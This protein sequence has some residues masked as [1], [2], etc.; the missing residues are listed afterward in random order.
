MQAVI[1]EQPGRAENVLVVRDLYKNMIWQG[2]GIDSWL[3]NAIPEQLATAQQELWKMLSE[4]LD[5][6]PVIDSFNPTQVHEALH[7]VLT[8]MRWHSTRSQWNPTMAYI[9]FPKRRHEHYVNN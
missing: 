7:V 6:S 4:C 3:N 1:F 2:F 5:L 8:T 9:P